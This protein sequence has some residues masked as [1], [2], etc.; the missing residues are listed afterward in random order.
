MNIQTM[1][2]ALTMEVMVTL[3]GE[4]GGHDKMVNSRAVLPAEVVFN[5]D[6]KFVSSVLIKIKSLI[7]RSSISC[8]A[9]S[10]IVGKSTPAGKAG[11]A[12]GTNA[13]WH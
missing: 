1:I 10:E 6:V 7:G 8:A 5:P 12:P 4:A 9:L 3:R 11:Y 13:G 2:S